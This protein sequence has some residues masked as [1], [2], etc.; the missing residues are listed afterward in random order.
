MYIFRKKELSEDNE[1]CQQQLNSSSNY[2]QVFVKSQLKFLST[3]D[4]DIN[5]TRGMLSVA[6]HHLSNSKL[7][8][9]LGQ[10]GP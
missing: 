4:D 3:D 6:L 5:D 9:W 1:V 7:K 8:T 2:Q 10:H